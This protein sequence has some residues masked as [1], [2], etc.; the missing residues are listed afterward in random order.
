MLLPCSFSFLPLRSLRLCEKFF[1]LPILELRTGEQRLA[2][3]APRLAF[4][5]LDGGAILRQ[6]CPVPLEERLGTCLFP[7]RG[8]AAVE[9][10]ER[11]TNPLRLGAV[12][13]E[14]TVGR[15]IGRTHHK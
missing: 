13:L 5:L 10:D 1:L 6:L 9:P 8:Q 7:G 2:E 15:R 3:G 12:A 14:Q 4:L 11:F